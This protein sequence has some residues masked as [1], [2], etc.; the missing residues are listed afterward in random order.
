MPANR[1]SANLL[2]IAL[3]LAA[4]AGPSFAQQQAPV[5]PS[6]EALAEIKSLRETLARKLAELKTRP[7]AESLLPDVEIFDKGADWIV[8]H[9]E[10]Y[11]PTYPE[12]TIAA[13]KAGIARV[14]ALAARKADWEKP[15]GRKVLA[16]RS[17][18]D[19]SVQPYAL[20]LP[21]GF[22]ARAEK[23]WPLYVVLHGRDGVL[24]E[25]S[26][27]HNHDG[28]PPFENQDWI[29]LDIFGRVNNAYRWAGETDVF[30]ALADVKRRFRIDERRIVLHG[31]SMGGAGAW[32]LGVHHP[33]RWCSVGPGAGFVEFYKYQKRPPLPA[34]QDQTL[35]I[36]NATDYAL[37]AFDVPICTYGGEK[38][39]QLAASTTMVAL[40]KELDIPVKLIIGPDTGHAFHPESL[41]E[42]MAFHRERAEKG[43]PE[44]SDINRIRFATWTLKY[45]TCDWLTVEEML[46]PYRETTVEARV[47]ENSGRLVV[48]TKNVGVLQLGR[49][50]ADEVELD[51]V[52]LPL[53]TAS[54]GLLPGVYYAGD[55]SSWR[56]LDYDSSLAFTNNADL[57]KRHNLQGPIDDAFMQP[58]VCV[59]GTGTAWNAA[60][61]AW[62]DWTR[63]RFATEFD[64]WMRARI[65]IVKDS[66]VTPEM[67]ASKNLILFGD[68]GS[69][70]LLAKVLPQLPVKW[71][72]DA[73]EVNGQK[74]DPAQHGLALI[75]PNPL[76]PRRYVVVNSGHTMHTPDFINSNAWLFP[77]LGDIAV[78][79]FT[80]LDAG[81]Y[82][83]ETAWAEIFDSEWKLPGKK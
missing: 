19:D 6:G 25:I 3:L 72:K 63:E 38:D 70:S 10:F 42:F 61:A 52:Q 18:V 49:D 21:A 9:G 82:G 54:G 17:A 15:P 53:R 29:Q 43:R 4:G 27:I 24:N 39:A 8:R 66:D 75:Y 1:L 35:H 7:D 28:K 2:M 13:L 30:E 67:I 62:A 64:K 23:R 83:E 60:H 59:R 78:Q 76:A 46:E 71:T 36:Y 14:E 57:H 5:Q 11:R 31:F 40:T 44:W 68:P 51:G 50:V 47:D 58:F 32:H 41:K 12:W 79:K 80:K 56:T 45:N 73:I 65:P 16:Y 33:S 20:A 74:Y 48:K 34:W 69:N 81:G 37:N 55:G 26:L 22:D 77:R